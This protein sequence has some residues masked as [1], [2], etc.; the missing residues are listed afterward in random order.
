[1]KSFVCRI[2]KMTMSHMLN[3]DRGDIDFTQDS[4]ADGMRQSS[5][6]GIYGQNG[7]GKT[8]CIHALRILHHCL[9]GFPLPMETK[10]FIQCGEKS[11][12]F[13]FEI[14]MFG[15]QKEYQVF[16]DFSIK[17]REK[18][19]GTD[20]YP[21][22]Y[23]DGEK[24]SYK[25][26]GS[27]KTVLLYTAQDEEKIAIRPIKFGKELERKKKDFLVR[28]GAIAGIS[29][30]Q[31]KS[32]VFSLQFLS[33]LRPLYGSLS[34]GTVLKDILEGLLVYAQQNFHVFG[35]QKNGLINLSI[36]MP[37]SLR[38]QQDGQKAFGDLL[39]PVRAGGRETS[40]SIPAQ[41]FHLAE[42]EL[43]E[44][45]PVISAII[46]GLK[47]YLRNL[48][49]EL[50]QNGNE[51][52]RMELVSERNGKDIPIRYE[53]EGIKKLVCLL[54]V[55][56][57]AFSNPSVTLAIDE[58]DAGVFEYLLGELLSVFKEQGK[59]QL[60]FTS[61]NLRP[62]E[63][64]DKSSIVFTTTNP[65]NRYIRLT[66]IKPNNN[67]RDIYYRGIQLGGAQEELYEQTDRYELAYALREAGK[68][69]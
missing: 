9:G 62:L 8:A 69:E 53:S 54:P 29:D 12:D 2:A 33:V 39:I 6:T 23:V 58:L 1:M 19:V 18:G 26:N 22:F 49:R 3:V 28:L 50:D 63:V 52:I 34:K 16:Y 4:T 46:P 14:L 43:A 41:M 32:I 10:D 21:P 35:N 30:V 13:S 24:L 20:G 68:N 67:L 47:V 55:L 45:N 61:H 17:R 65:N 37:L 7:S 15:E 11:A 57:G 31:G 66:G 48:G 36:G 25:L 64:L 27:K 42:L 56:I 38:T 60:I 40:I 5:I 51:M 44:I 59:G